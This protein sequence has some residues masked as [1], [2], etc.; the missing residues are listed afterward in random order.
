MLQ[1][2]GNQAYLR[3][4]HSLGILDSSCDNA[5]RLAASD[6]VSESF[7][8]ILFLGFTFRLALLTAW[9][10]GLLGAILA[11]AWFPR[12]LWAILTIAGGRCGLRKL[13]TLGADSDCACDGFGRSGIVDRGLAGRV[14]CSDGAVRDGRCDGARDDAGTQGDGRGGSVGVGGGRELWLA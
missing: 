8:L 7:S 6:S 10:L 13:G 3:I 12:L 11:V 4:R 9:F 5:G 14:G 1:K 2:V